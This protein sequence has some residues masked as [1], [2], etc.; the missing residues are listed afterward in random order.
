MAPA[1]TVVTRLTQERNVWLVTVRADG[2]PHAVPIWFAYIDD[3]FWVA[4]G[5]GSV[6]VRNLATN[7]QVTMALE[8][9]SAPVVAEGTGCVHPMPFPAPVVDAFRAKYQWDFSSGQDDDVGEVALV[10]VTVR[11]WLFGGTP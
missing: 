3:R 6:K 1:P 8:D 11:R 2:R 5:A 7:P 4:T 10:E 9:G